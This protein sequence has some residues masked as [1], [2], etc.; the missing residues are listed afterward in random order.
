MFHKGQQFVSN[1]GNLVEIE[2]R[3]ANCLLYFNRI[4]IREDDGTF[5]PQ[6]D[7][8]WAVVPEAWLYTA[9]ESGVMKPYENLFEKIGRDTGKTDHARKM[10][11]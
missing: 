7:G 5:R 8:R 3:D 2:K 6:A 11:Y 1:I 10:L 4:G 9:L